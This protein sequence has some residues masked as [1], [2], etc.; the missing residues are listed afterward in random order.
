MLK[1]HVFLLLIILFSNI[2][3]AQILIPEWST[4]IYVEDAKG[5]KDSILIGYDPRAL[6]QINPEFG[7]MAL[8]KI[9]DS[10]LDVRVVIC[11][12]VFCNNTFKYEYILSKVG[13]DP[14]NLEPNS[15]TSLCRGIMPRINF[16]IY[17]KYKPIKI[18]WQLEHWRDECHSGSFLVNHPWSETVVGG[19]GLYGRDYFCLGRD[20]KDV[21]WNIVPSTDFLHWNTILPTMDGRMDTMYM[22]QIGIKRY[23]F[24]DNPCR[25]S[26]ASDLSEDT[27]ISIYPNP[28]YDNVNIQSEHK[29]IQVK[30]YTCDGKL[31]SNIPAVDELTTINV[32][33]ISPGIKIMELIDDFGLIYR[34]KWVK[35]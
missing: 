24:F 30:I 10:V 18:S 21:I 27:D 13:I 28:A 16:A 15:N 7:E 14:P 11:S 32:G 34:R 12:E 29:F 5:N 26:D 2:S 1:F 20:Q 31:E 19:Y 25:F 9:L 17:A 8:P 35:I 3:L 4:T 22:Q 23:D 6:N 33:S